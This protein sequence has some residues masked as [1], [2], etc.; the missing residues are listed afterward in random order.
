MT[1]SKQVIESVRRKI[2]LFLTDDNSLLLLTL[3]MGWFFTTGVRL[4]YPVLIP[5]IRSTFG[6]NNTL[7]G[8]LFTVMVVM[9]ALTQF[10][11]GIMSDLF[12]ERT[13]LLLSIVGS[14]IATVLLAGASAFSVF[15]V[16]CILYGLAAG[17]FQSPTI[18]SLT[19]TFP[20]RSGSTHGVIFASGSIGTSVLPVIAGGVAVTLGWR[21]AYVLAIPIFALL[22]PGIWYLVPERKPE[23]RSSTSSNL[24]TAVSGLR[25]VFRWDLLTV[26]SAM[27]LVVIVFHGVSAFL[28]T[29]LIEVKGTSQSVATTVFGLFFIGGFVLQLIAGVG[30][31]RWSNRAILFAI[32]VIA[33]VSAVGL[34]RSSGIIPITVLSIALSS[35]AAYI[36]VANT[37]F[38][39]VLPDETQGS[40]I[41]AIRTVV[42]GIGGMSPLIT[43]YFGDANQFDLAF[44]L[45]GGSLIIAAGILSVSFLLP[46][47]E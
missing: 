10:P 2:T 21:Y 25:A 1:S 22:I 34:T 4:I 28:P 40:G 14:T 18:S 39:S 11:S 27:I 7:A 35:V 20:D 12:G 36:S 37:Y 9:I 33:A 3:A 5:Q 24:D 15:L 32:T 46:Q 41:G 45:F 31:D 23:Q 26:V 43:G 16:G 19:R 30:A 42:I 17:L 8:L 29:Y 44:L 13:V 38:A 6:I 47:S